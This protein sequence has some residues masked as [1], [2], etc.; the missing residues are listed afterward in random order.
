MS[1]NCPHCG[2]DLRGDPIPQE[3]IDAGYYAPGTTHY[4]RN[5]GVEVPGIYD[6][7]LYWQCPDC[8][9]AWVRN[10]GRGDRLDALSAECVERHNKEVGAA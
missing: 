3:Y 7:I 8:L 5:I 4:R 2:A 10:F 6:G 1:D 9:L